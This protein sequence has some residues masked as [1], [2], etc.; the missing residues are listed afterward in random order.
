MRFTFSCFHFAP[1]QSPEAVAWTGAVA[2]QTSAAAAIAICGQ[3]LFT[4]PPFWLHN[5]P[6]GWSSCAHSKRC[7]DQDDDNSDDDG[8]ECWSS[9]I[10]GCI[11]LLAGQS[12][13]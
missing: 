3:H 13:S 6:A 1:P 2:D 5:R 11:Y 10:I 7:D 8:E 12:L 4:C 9:V